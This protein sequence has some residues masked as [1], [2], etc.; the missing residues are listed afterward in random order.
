MKATKLLHNLLDN[1][2]LTRYMD[3]LSVTGLTSNPTIFDLAIKNSSAYDS[4]ILDGLAAGQSG[5]IL[6]FE[7]ALEDI[8][9]AADLHHIDKHGEDLPE[10]RNWRWQMK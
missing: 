6:F 7:L 10:V 2:A 3:D 8:I 4:A 9:R 5:K 1:G